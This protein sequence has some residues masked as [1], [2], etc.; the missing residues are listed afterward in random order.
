MIECVKCL[1]EIYKYT[2][3]YLTF[4]NII[5]CNNVLTK[6]INDNFVLYLLR[7]AILMSIQK[8]HW[9]LESP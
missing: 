7:K 6:L 2:K 1:F 5:D 4:I 3:G 8:Y 9:T